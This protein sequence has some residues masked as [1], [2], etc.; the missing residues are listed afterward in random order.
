MEKRPSDSKR[1]IGEFGEFGLIELISKMVG[2]PTDGVI[3]GIG[4]D[5][6]AVDPPDGLILLTS[7]ML[8]ED[9]HFRL[10]WLKP[11]ELG[12][13][14]IAVNMSDVAAMAGVPIFALISLA[15][16]PELAVSVVEEFYLGALEA[17][18]PH[19]VRIV[20]G[21][22]SRG[23]KL[24]IGVALV[25]SVERDL[26]RRRD[27]ARPGEAVLVTGELG[28]SAAGLAILENPDLAS[29]TDNAERLISAHRAPS[30]RVAE[31]REASRRGAR[32]MEDIS[33]G[34]ASEIAHI[35]KMSG[36]GAE[37]F[38]DSIPI[39]P[40]VKEIAS[41]MGKGPLDLALFGGEDYE[42]VFTA[43][44]E[45]VEAIR[46]AI[47]ELG[48]AISEIGRITEKREIALIKEGSASPLPERGYAHF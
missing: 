23:E 27:E 20:G 38:A 34:L 14:S 10:D 40:G 8:V 29:A 9:V 30:A 2:R 15:L 7:D 42:L 41:A 48:V 16:R 47:G 44:P 26:I 13:K 12:Y 3:V 25:G 39:A 18:E 5:A 4:D 22:V 21:D 45:S 28:A 1:K 19:G 46:K 31:A 36:V 35:C 24:A 6:A 11:R 33:D 17:C 37:I 32:A 43:H